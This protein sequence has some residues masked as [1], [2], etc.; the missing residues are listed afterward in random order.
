MKKGKIILTLLFGLSYVLSFSQQQAEQRNSRDAKRRVVPGIRAGINRSNVYDEQGENFVANKKTGFA[1]GVFVALPIGSF[2]GI[3]PELLISQKGFSSRGT[4]YGDQ[5]FLERTST[6]LDIP[7][8]LQLKP[9][10]FFTLLGGVQYSYL[11]SQRDAFTNGTNTIAQSQE[12]SNDNIRKN[13]FGTLLGFDI[14]IRHVVLSGRYGWDLRANRGDGSS[15]TPRYKN[16]WA[17]ATIGYRF[18]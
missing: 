3:Q 16:V 2:I 15:Y 11:L 1:G 17:Q 9:T 5:Y 6:F 4:M 10:R 8:Q 14:N 18:Y 12:F 7:L 13:I